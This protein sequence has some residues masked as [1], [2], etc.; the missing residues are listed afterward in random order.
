MNKTIN[1]IKTF[2]TDYNRMTEEQQYELG[3][4][5]NF[6]ESSIMLLVNPI[7]GLQPKF[8]EQDF[9]NLYESKEEISGSDFKDRK[10]MVISM[11]NLLYKI[12]LDEKDKKLLA[13]SLRKNK[14]FLSSV[15]MTK[16]KFSV[17]DIDLVE[18]ALKYKYETQN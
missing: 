9:D 5:V 15:Q 7:L 18:K 14:E 3:T 11:A 2:G 1:K 6:M 8:T 17:E 16:R 10:N 4:Y 13:K 12:D